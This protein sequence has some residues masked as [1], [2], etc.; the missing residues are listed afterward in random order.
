[1][2][3]GHDLVERRWIPKGNPASDPHQSRR[4]QLGRRS[5]I[6]DPRRADRS[7]GLVL[8]K[9]KIFLGIG[10]I[11]GF[12]GSGRKDFSRFLSDIWSGVVR[13]EK[14]QASFK[15]WIPIFFPP[16]CRAESLLSAGAAQPPR[17]PPIGPFPTSL[18]LFG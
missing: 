13:L 9:E 8:G 4:S 15:G 5:T 3:W 16:L 14:A 1:M 10:S 6:S 12:A 17:R 7:T 18:C 2:S 11:T